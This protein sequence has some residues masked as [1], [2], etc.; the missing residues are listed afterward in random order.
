MEATTGEAVMYST[1]R[2]DE[3]AKDHYRIYWVALNGSFR[4]AE[5]TLPTY[6]DLRAL[7]AFGAL[8]LPSPLAMGGFLITYGPW[9]LQQEG[10]GVTYGAA[11][12]RMLF[13]LWP[14]VMIAQL[15]AVGLAALCYRRQDRYGASRSECLV[16]SIFVFALGL[17]GWIAYRFGRSWPVLQ[18][19]PACGVTAPQDR[20]NCAPARPTS[21]R[22]H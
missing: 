12:S 3:S 16:W 9:S 17:P 18:T 7:R 21:R 13:G 19:C 10:L 6:S 5:V 1:S 22:Q 2:L 20:E 15:L 4:Q 8:V 14:A 11:L